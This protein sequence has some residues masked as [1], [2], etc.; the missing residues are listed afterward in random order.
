MKGDR[1]A[2]LSE[3]EGRKGR[4][5]RIDRIDAPEGTSVPTYLK[6]L[7]FQAGL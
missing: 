7:H 6:D 2:A 4:F 1:L 5:V 3:E